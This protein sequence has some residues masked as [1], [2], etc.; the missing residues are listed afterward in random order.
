MPFV[1]TAYFFELDNAQQMKSLTELTKLVI[2]R[3]RA[4]L[5]CA[6]LGCAELWCAKAVL[7]LL[8]A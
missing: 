1:A 4:V 7:Y 8:A 5:R 3:C 6:W 2:V